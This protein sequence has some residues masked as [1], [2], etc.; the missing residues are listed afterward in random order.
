MLYYQTQY[1]L[2]NILQT[3]PAVKY[4]SK[5][6]QVTIITHQKYLEPVRAVYRGW[7]V[8]VK[9]PLGEKPVYHGAVPTEF[10]R[11]G[12]VSEVMLNLR[13]VGC[14]Y[15]KDTDRTGFCGYQ[16]TGDVFDIVLCNGYQKG[17]NATDWAVKSWP[18]WAAVIKHF[19]HLQIAS[20]G[21]PDEYLPG[22]HDCTGIGLLETLGLIRRAKLVVANDTGLYHAACVFGVPVVVLFTMTDRDKNYDPVFHQSAVPL[23][24]DLPCQPCQL[25]APLYWLEQKSVCGWACRD[26]PPDI[27][28][29]AIEGLLWDN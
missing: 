1:G 20:V 4:L 15:P 19:G 18:H 17:K 2:G 10:K 27:V 22:T 11:L 29:A 8:M 7:P 16:D 9:I 28:I 26:I 3:T 12:G 5:R 25:T 14:E 21:L 24:T 23:C 13:K 6:S